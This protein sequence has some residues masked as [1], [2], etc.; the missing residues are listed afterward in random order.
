M[1]QPVGEIF[2]KVRPDFSSFGSE[3]NAGMQKFSGAGVGG[4]AVG[5]SAMAGAI[6]SAASSNMPMAVRLAQESFY[7][8]SAA[9]S[10]GLAGAI[11]MIDQQIGLSTPGTAH[12]W[13][14]P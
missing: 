9:R 11:S 12:H 14:G 4:G 6:G 8:A 7:R 13:R 10:Q 5:G 2:V 1:S 3:M